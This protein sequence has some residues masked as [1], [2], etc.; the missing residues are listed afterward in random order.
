MKRFLLV[1]LILLLIMLLPAASFDF[2]Q[3]KNRIHEFTLEK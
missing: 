3:I 2:S 1:L